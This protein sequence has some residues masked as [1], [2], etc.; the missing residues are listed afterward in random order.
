MRAP[1]TPSRRHSAQASPLSPF[2]VPLP[3]TTTHVPM[4][5]GTPH[6]ADSSLPPGFMPM[7]GPPMSPARVPLPHSSGQMPM[8]LE[9]PHTPQFGFP[10]GF[11]PVQGPPEVLE[12]F[13]STAPPKTPGMRSSGLPSKT[14]RLSTG[15]LPPQGGFSGFTPS[16]IPLPLSSAHTNAGLPDVSSA[17]R[18]SAYTAYNELPRT[19]ETAYEP[20]QVSSTKYPMT[21]SRMPLPDSVAGS[22]HGS[23]AHRPLSAWGEG[24]L[25]AG[26]SGR[27]TTPALGR[28]PSLYAGDADIK[29][30]VSSTSLASSFKKFDPSTYVDPAYL[31]SG[32]ATALPNSAVYDRF[33]QHERSRP[34]SLRSV[35]SNKSRYAVSVETAS[36][37]DD[38]P[39]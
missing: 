17:P 4:S 33:S 38:P 7:Q 15:T 23:T 18:G 13:S 34:G 19:A 25:T 8:N 10:R 35:K 39:R 20:A 31:A 16:G 27:P 12:A 37:E 26:V 28:P 24:N 29:K 32:S 30:K 21:P 36:D 1:A 11:I 14:P 22:P 2:M 3:P 6:P 9:T 5:L